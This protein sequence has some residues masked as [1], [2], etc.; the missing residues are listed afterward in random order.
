MRRS[1]LHVV[2]GWS[3]PLHRAAPEMRGS[4]IAMLACANMIAREP[5]VDHR[6]LL[7]GP[8]TAVRQAH[9]LGLKPFRTFSPPA[10]MAR[11]AWRAVRSAARAFESTPE[12]MPWGKACARAVRLAGFPVASPP[13]LESILADRSVPA[14]AEAPT[15]E[16]LSIADDVLVFVA[17]TDPPSRLDSLCIVRMLSM[18][19]VEGIRVCGLLPSGAWSF[20]RGRRFHRDVGLHIDLRAVDAPWPTLLGI[21]D[22]AVFSP[23][24]V[25]ARQEAEELDRAALGLLSRT[26][27]RTILPFELRGLMT[28][29]SP[30]N[31]ILSNEPGHAPMARAVLAS[32]GWKPGL[33][34][35]APQSRATPEIA[36]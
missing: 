19:D 25:H 27:T 14:W 7:L 4:S 17:A 15:R 23:R 2:Q 24:P 6:V 31:L 10:G 36:R 28:E 30:T 33:L 8:R 32:L 29:H 11:L 5:E 35:S 34:T 9:Q 12:I 13:P 20:E 1:I 21:A 22:F 18:F 3:Q 26:G 16:R